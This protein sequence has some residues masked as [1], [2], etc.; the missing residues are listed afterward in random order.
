MDIFVKP[1][2]NIE[3]EVY[4]WEDKESHIIIASN[5]V[6]DVPKDI[7][8]SIVKCKFRK[9]TY[10]VDIMSF[11]DA[12]IRS[13]LIE[14]TYNGETTD[15]KTSTINSLNP[16]IARAAVAAILPKINL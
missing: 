8:A 14:I 16:H 7:E 13:L 2:D 4:A 11:Q 9:P 5:D 6:K 10:Q 12:I 15:M 1:E 3:I